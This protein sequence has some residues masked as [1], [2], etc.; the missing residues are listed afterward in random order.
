MFSLIFLIFFCCGM[1]DSEESDLG[2]GLNIGN[3]IDVFAK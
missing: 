2:Y 1:C 3:A